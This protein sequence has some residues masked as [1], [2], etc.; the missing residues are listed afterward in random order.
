MGHTRFDGSNIVLGG[1]NLCLILFTLMVGNNQKV[2]NHVALHTVGGEAGLVGHFGVILVEIFRQV[3]LRLFDEL[4]IA[5]ATH[6]NSHID[7]RARA[8][9]RLVKLGRNVESPYPT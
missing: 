6:N 9:L 4:Q 3:Q 7:G 1:L 2:V 8:H 5:R